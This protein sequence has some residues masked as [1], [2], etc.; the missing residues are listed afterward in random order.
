MYNCTNT[1]YNTWKQFVETVQKIILITTKQYY[2]YW[3]YRFIM[4]CL[5]SNNI[6]HVIIPNINNIFLDIV[7]GFKLIIYFMVPPINPF[8]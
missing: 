2:K 6:V 5:S 8:W 7:I 3:D 1:I 4:T